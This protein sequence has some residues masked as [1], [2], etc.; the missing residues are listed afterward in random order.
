MISTNDIKR[1]R[2]KTGAGILD[3]REAL[4]R[5]DGDS[6]KALEILREKGAEL[7]EKRADK[8]AAHGYVTTY[9]HHG[10]IGVMVE[11]RCETDFVSGNQGFRELAHEIALQVAAGSPRWVCR[12]EVPADVVEQIAVD[13]RARATKAGKPDRILEQI[14]AGKV[15]RFY[16]DNCLLEQPSIRDDKTT[17]NALIQDK[18]VA[19]GERIYVNQFARFAIES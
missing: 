4:R 14:V 3:C 19:F 16:R 1:L 12:D 15:D 2:D 7:I 10:L 11:L 18:L 17:V 9:S 13:E 6:D 8:E 5:C